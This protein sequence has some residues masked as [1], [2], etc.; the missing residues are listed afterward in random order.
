MLN[1]ADTCTRHVL[2]KLREAGWD[3]EPHSF[4]EQQFVQFTDG[5]ARLL[6]LRIFR[7]DMIWVPS[8]RRVYHSK[9]VWMKW[10]PG[11]LMV[12][13]AVGFFIAASFG[14]SPAVFIAVGVIFLVASAFAWRRARAAP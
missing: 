4:N 14:K 8:V 6:Y 12:V 1:E 3:A 11:S 9:E 5:R 13:V 2:P 7:S 10:L